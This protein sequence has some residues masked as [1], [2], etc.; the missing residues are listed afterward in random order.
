MKQYHLALYYTCYPNSGTNT[1]LAVALCK[2]YAQRQILY[3]RKRKVHFVERCTRA[4]FKTK[5]YTLLQHI[6]LP[7]QLDFDSRNIHSTLFILFFFITRT[8]GQT[9]RQT[10]GENITYANACVSQRYSLL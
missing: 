8:D 3:L 5:V 4:M 2:T 7:R 9:D 6:R 10:Y 1:L